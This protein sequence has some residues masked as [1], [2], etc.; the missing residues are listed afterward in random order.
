MK[1]PAFVRV[2][3]SV[4]VGLWGMASLGA[5]PDP[6]KVGQLDISKWRGFNLLEKFTAGKNAP[7]VEDDFKWIAELGFNFVRLP[8]DYRCY[9]EKDDWLKFKEPALKEIDQAIALARSTRSTFA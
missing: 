6:Q 1:P 2:V 8:M 4:I 9:V 5:A 3:A 7:F